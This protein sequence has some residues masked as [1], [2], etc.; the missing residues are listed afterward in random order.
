MWAE[1]PKVDSA[2]E[3]IRGFSLW[4]VGSIAALGASVCMS[5]LSLIIDAVKHRVLDPLGDG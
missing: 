4:S 1:H 3:R 2:I 5:N